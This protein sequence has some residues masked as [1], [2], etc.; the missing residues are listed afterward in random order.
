MHA[1]RHFAWP[2]VLF[3][4]PMLFAAQ[5]ATTVPEGG[6]SIT[7]NAG[8]V[9]APVTTSFVIPLIDSPLA[10]GAGVARIA[11]FTATTVTA[12]APGWAAGALATTAFPYAFRIT[13]GTVA[14]AIFAI[15]ANTIDTLST[16]GVD[17]LT[18]GLVSGPS[19]D[20][21]RLIPVDTLNTLFGSST[22]LGGTSQADADVVILSSNAQLAYYYNNTL[23]RWVRTTGPTI[24]R[25]NTPIPFDS[26]ISI[27][28]KAAAL[29]L[30]FSGRVPDGRFRLTV[31]NSGSTYTHTGFPTDVTLSAFSLQ[32]ALPGWVSSPVAN[33][34]DA[35]SVGV[36]A[37]SL[38]YFHNGTN[39]QR[40]TGPALNRDAI[41]IPAGTAIQIFKLGSTAG[42]STLVRNV[43]Y[44]F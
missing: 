18:L 23:A 16:T 44:S 6:L 14:G 39:W 32:S 4:G 7:I 37:A 1:I 25:G 11:S 3:M 22:L 8:S 41:A 34:A 13:S 17:L 29:T 27:N 12:N 28:R 40:T 33:S 15:S 19:G 31:P 36:G 26:V 2:V 35:L 43:P 5:S 38:T 20:S 24:D 30:R 42:T 21:F 10:T 9:P